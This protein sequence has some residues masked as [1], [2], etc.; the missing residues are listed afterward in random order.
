MP[1]LPSAWA[2][3][4]TPSASC[5]SA[6][7]G[8]CGG[9]WRTVMPTNDDLAR[10]GEPPADDTEQE[11]AECLESV[12]QQQARGE[13]PIPAV[14]VS[15]AAD[16]LEAAARLDRLIGRILLRSGFTAEYVLPEGSTDLFLPAVEQAGMPAPPDLTLPQ[17]FPGEYRVRAL[18]GE[19]SFCTVW[20]ADDLRAD[21]SVALKHV[22]LEAFGRQHPA[23]LMSLRQEAR[24]LARVQHPNLIRY[25]TWRQ[26]GDEHYLVLQYVAGGSLEGR[27]AQGGPLDWRPAARYVADVGEA[28]LALHDR[29]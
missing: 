16:A 9:C 12:R 20:L 13:S 21:M 7:C 3:A 28:L 6:P 22:K 15:P 24:A 2:A 23:A 19:G 25:Y 5:A 10:W 14:P 8:D 29:G 4:S 18:L 17:P 1:R 27:L 11:L 26:A